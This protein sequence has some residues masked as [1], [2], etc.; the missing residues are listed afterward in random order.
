MGRNIILLT[1][2]LTSIIL[3]QTPT[4]QIT[5]VISDATGAAVAGAEIDAENT[6]TGIR[7][8]A[9]TNETGSYSFPSLTPGAYRVTARKEG[10]NSASRGGIELQV[11]QVAR[12][13]FTLNVGST[14]ETVEV[15]ATAPLLDSESASLGTTVTTKAVAQLPLNGRNFLQLARLSAGVVEPKQGDRNAAGGSFIANGVRAQLNNFLL[16]GI[17]NNSK[18]VD[19]QN[20]APVVVQPSVDAVQEFRVETNNY[21]AEYGYSAGA[22]VNATIKGGTNQFHGSAFEFVRNDIFD[23]RN[24]FASP[25]APK[26][27]LRRNQFGLTGGGPI[28]RNKAFVFGSWERTLERNGITYVT[29]VP[30]A[31]M[32]AGDLTGLAQV[33]DPATTQAIGNGVY[34]RQ[35]FAG[36]RIPANRIDPAAAKLLAALP[37]PTTSGLFNNYVVSPV[38]PVTTNRLDFRHDLNISEKDNLFA[39]FSRFT[40]AYQYP[41][42]FPAP[43]IGSTTFQNSDKSTLG[44]GAGLGETHVFSGRFVNEFRAGYNRIFDV[45]SPY[46]KDSSVNS[47]FG[48]GGIPA[49]PGLGGLPQMTIAGFT[50]LGEATFLPNSKISETITLQDNVSLI[51]GRH[52]LKTGFMYRWVR[53]WYNISSSA[54]GTYTF[55][56]GFSQDPQNRSRT[57][58]GIAD[59]LLGIPSGAGI[60]NFLSG[61]IR[62]KYAGAFIQDDWKLTTRLTLNLGL[63]YEIWT[64]PIERNDLQANFFLADRKL[65]F[66]DNKVPA[67]LPASVVENVPSEVDARSLMRTY[68]ALAPRLGFAWQA[69]PSF[70]VRGGAGMF[71]ADA[72]FLGA[73]GRL[74]AN[75]PYAISNS[76][77]TDNIT[78]IVLLGT[79]FPPTATTAADFSSVN[80]SAFAPDMKN[81]AVYHWSFGIQKQ[82]AG[83]VLE[84]N[85]VGT[86][87]VSLPLTYQ[88][89]QAL[90]GP[91]SVAS[92][93]PYQ[94]FNNILL[95]MSAGL[96]RYNALEVKAERRY[97]NGLSLISA[98]TFSRALDNG[99]EQ[100]IGDL[101][102]R[103]VNNLNWE[104]ALSSGN[105]S[106]RFV[107]G[108]LYD[109]PFGAGR[110]FGIGNAALNAVAGGWQLNTIVTVHT[111]QPFTPSLGVSS[112][113]TGDPRP[114]RIGNGN[115]PSD[116]RNIQHWFDQSAFIS[117]PQYLYGNAG[118]NVLIGPGAA[119]VDLSLFKRFAL[120]RLH[121]GTELQFRVEGFNI[122]N[123]PQF[124]QPNARVD[125]PVGGSIT[126]LSTPMRQ[127]QFG[128]KLLF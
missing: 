52:T 1:L 72:P 73:S 29:T 79:G 64:Q 37:L 76:Y 108:A 60:S 30:T 21:S 24:Y 105:I 9:Q 39:R 124:G 51:L 112:A 107:A 5:G 46:V 114:N 2:A 78:P 18:I 80:V 115:L 121:E 120:S 91:G 63:R 83:F 40:Y 75:P 106:H 23:A 61:D 50:T 13:D 98:Y 88:A 77:P 6:A 35:A 111:G 56:G 10:F 54:R 47:Q 58:T 25:T 33:Y 8:T 93:R 44:Y 66:A 84:S 123:H 82:V 65:A 97:S 109:L 89:N 92:R 81:G 125:L 116:Q 87:G 32:R 86:R 67:G 43:I 12:I 128:L 34:T 41:G 101:N 14:K 20:S 49:Q 118:R 94:G 68:G 62:Y 28:V 4:G 48:L 22:V 38:Q 103:D 15:K 57:G 95:T 100:L 59:F 113:N 17:D 27:V 117:P 7:F 90:A 45:L 71:Y 53:S 74:P 16:D 31:A 99:G 110:K 119:N 104:Y 126:S 96:S 42:P 102:L 36:N 11:S 122:F 19:Q 85:Y 127:L 26:P 69:A 70:V 3:A 55:S